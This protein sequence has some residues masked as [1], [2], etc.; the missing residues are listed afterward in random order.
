[1]N[2]LMNLLLNKQQPVQQMQQPVMG[3]QMQAP[4]SSPVPMGQPLPAMGGNNAMNDLMKKYH[5]IRT[6]QQQPAQGVIPGQPGMQPQQQ[7]RPG[8]MGMF[9][10]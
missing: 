2:G 1:M 9:R 7:R 3:Q 10:G 4:M 5:Q 8:M 6:Q